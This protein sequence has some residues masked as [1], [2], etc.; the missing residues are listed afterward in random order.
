[1]TKLDDAKKRL[2]SLRSQRD[3]HFRKMTPMYPKMT[4]Q[5]CRHFEEEMKKFARKISAA[6]SAVTRLT[7]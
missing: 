1:M 2:E 7:K 4:A 3:A 5:D 6:K